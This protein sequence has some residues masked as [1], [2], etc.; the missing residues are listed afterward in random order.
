MSRVRKDRDMQIVHFS[1]FDLLFG[2]FGAFVFLMLMQVIK[3]MNLVD[4]DIQ[5]NFDELVD[6]KKSLIT[7]L[8]GYKEQAQLRSDLENRLQEALSQLKRSEEEKNAL[9]GQNKD[10]KS[11]MDELESELASLGKIR[12]EYTRKGDIQKALQN[13]NEQLRKSLSE[14][15]QR[16]ASL[17]P[18]EPSALN[19]KTRSFP[20][21]LTGENVNLPMS[22]EGG[23]P[24]YIWDYS[25]VMPDGLS[26]DKQNGIITG[27]TTKN[28]DYRFSIKVS[29]SS[30][31]DAVSSDE[32]VFQVVDRPDEKKGVSKSFVFMTII[33]SLLLIYVLIGKYRV[34]LYCKRMRAQGYK[35][36]WVKE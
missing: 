22:V 15:N 16:L 30:G 31:S 29:D 7:Q 17:K 9:L 27:Q 33:S 32:I 13:E 25:G 36:I 23:I 3:T 21:T 1:F 19:L 26:F 28:G 10:N 18:T 6:E 8:S 14:A 34:H 4:V 12:D 11:K 20:A 24:P 2:A 5:K 35:P